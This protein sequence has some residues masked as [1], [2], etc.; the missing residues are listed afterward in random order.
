MPVFAASALRPFTVRAASSSP[1]V[2]RMPTDLSLEAA[3]D[4][5]PSMSEI[6]YVMVLDIKGALSELIEARRPR[7]DLAHLIRPNFVAAEPEK[8]TSNVLNLAHAQTKPHQL[9]AERHQAATHQLAETAAVARGRDRS[10]RARNL[11]DPGLNFFGRTFVAKETQDDTD[12]FFSHSIINA[13][14]YGQPPYQFVHIAPPSTGSA[15]APC[16]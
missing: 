7:D 15:P 6:G 8:F 2:V 4:G 16:L 14:L 3:K 12:G 1:V 9:G 13:G 5:K 10:F 11:V